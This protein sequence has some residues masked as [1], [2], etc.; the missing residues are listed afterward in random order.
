FPLPSWAVTST[1][2][3]I[4]VPAVVV[5]G[6]TLNTNCVAV[7]AV[8]LN[9]VLVPVT[10]PGALAVSV[11]PVPTLSID[12]PVNVAT[13]P[14]AAWVAVPDKAPPD[15][16][17]PMASVTLP[18][19]PVA[20][21]PLASW[22]VTSTAGVILAPAAV[23]VGSTDNTRL[24]ALTAVVLSV[25]LVVLPAPVAV[26]VSPV[27][28]YSTAFPA[29]VA[30]PPDAAWVAVPDKAPPDGLVPM[31]SVT[32]PVNPVAVLLLASR[33][34]T[35]TA[36]VIVAP[37]DVVLG[38]TENTSCVAVPA[39]MLNA[40]RSALPCPVA[41]SAYPVPT[42]SIDSQANVATPAHAAWVA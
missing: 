2:G 42:L 35:C 36:G 32:L 24:E 10:G 13:P 34:V 23:L 3:V 21:L 5:L 40:V 37:A 9:A 4:A 11:Y 20:V 19:N 15:G 26:R 27:P 8:M 39:V 1:A 38:S 25:G 33:A 7:P 22:A 12:R 18:V 14:D 28:P 31:A 17:V 6:C 41:A 30:T 29:N 16:L